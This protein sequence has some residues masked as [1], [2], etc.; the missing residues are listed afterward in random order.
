MVLGQKVAIFDWEWGRNSAPREGQKIPCQKTKNCSMSQFSFN[1]D[2]TL[3][4]SRWIIY[5]QWH[6][7]SNNVAFWHVD[8]DE[9]LQ[10][11]FKLRNSKWCSVSSLTIIASYGSYQTARM[12]RL[13][14]GFADLTYH[15]VGN[16]MSRLIYRIS[17]FWK[18][19]NNLIVCVTNKQTK[20]PKWGA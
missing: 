13:I 10:P 2:E 8:S 7:I 3:Q 15:I 11:P 12:P 14:W 5:E 9:P 19:L 20:P 16:L 18:S 1:L 17:I 6:E 4:T